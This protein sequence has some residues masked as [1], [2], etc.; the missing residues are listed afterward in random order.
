MGIVTDSTTLEDPK[1]PETCNVVKIYSLL[2]SKEEIKDLHAK[3]REGGF[4]YGESKKLLLN[5]IFEQFDEARSKYQ[6]LYPKKDYVY[7]ILEEGA[8]KAKKVASKTLE[9]VKKQVG[10]R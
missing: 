5:K 10:Y 8:I 2:S 7:G 3:Y 4:G 1:D 6:K 9:A